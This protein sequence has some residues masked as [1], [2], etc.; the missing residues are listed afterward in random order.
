MSQDRP[1]PQIPTIPSW[2]LEI[3]RCPRTGAR[4]T[5]GTDDDGEAV[6]ISDDSS[7]PLVYPVRDGVPVLLAEEAR[8][9]S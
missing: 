6:L 5:L 4:L 9:L 1:E 3:L 8:Q 2:L 7:R